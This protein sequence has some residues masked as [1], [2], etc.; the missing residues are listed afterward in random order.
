MSKR[1]LKKYISGLN[2]AQ[3]QEQI[4]DL[5]DR[6]KN[7]KEYYDFVFNPQENKLVEECKFKITKE[8]FP[9]NGRKPKARRSIAQKYIKHFITIGLENSLIA[10][11]MLY[12]I[13][14]AQSFSKEKYIKNESFY[15]SIQKSFEQAVDFIDK[16]NLLKEFS[17]RIDKIVDETWAQEWFNKNSFIN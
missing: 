11:I 1:D 4:T 14:I 7:V 3:L 5:Y 17:T 6:F 15:I 13:E 9:V 2:K 10:D 16:N 12:N 8:Y